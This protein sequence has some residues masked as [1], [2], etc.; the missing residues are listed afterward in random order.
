M[1]K[2]INGRILTENEVLQGYSLI[3]E[4]DKIIDITN[5]NNKYKCVEIDVNNKLITPGLIDVHS[6]FIETMVSPRKSSLVDPKLAISEAEKSLLACGIT[7]MYHSLSL[8]GDDTFG[9]KEVRKRENVNKIINAINTIDTGDHLIRH[10]MHLRLEVTNIPIID[11]LKYFINNKMLDLLSF[12]DHTPGQGQYR[13]LE[14]YK[15]AIDILDFAPNENKFDEIVQK[16]INAT[17]INYENIKEIADLATKNSI[18]IASHDDDSVEKIELAKNLNTI[19]SE[20][21][22]T[23]DVAK[24]AKIKG[25]Y[26]LVGAPNILNGGSHSGNLCATTAIKNNAVDIICSDY[27]PQAMIQS[28]FKLHYEQNI[29]LC[30]AF[31][32]VTYNPAK[33]LNILNKVGVIKVGNKA[34]LLIIN[35]EKDVLTINSVIIDGIEVMNLNYRKGNDNHEF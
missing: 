16:Q 12:M 11:D 22:I 20:F 4:G 24:F 6:D 31:K 5:D 17:K 30:E 26:T 1:I 8:F 23:L 29:S 2:Y 28:V 25:L 14:N 18:T 7:T 35:D 34:D 3:I 10:R 9:N 21:P 27:Y 32:Y 15:D 33:A 13:N 19:I